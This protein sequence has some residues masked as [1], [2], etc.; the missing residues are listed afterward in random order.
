MKNFIRLC[1]S[2]P[3]TVIMILGAVF[4]GAGFSLSTL[5]LEK[6]PE[7]NYP[8]VTVETLYPGMGA[9]EMRSI[10]TIPVEDA[11]SSV[12]GLE[13]MRSVSRAGSSL[14]VLDF[15][16][17]LDAN[18]AS[19][20]VREAIDAVY[21]S[22]P[23][24][25]SKPT[26]VPGD[27][28][29]E[30]HAIIAVR[31]RS[32]D[33]VFA[34]NL[35]EYELRSRLRRIEG[36]GS[37]ILCGGEKP[38]LKLYLDIRKAAAQGFGVSGFSQLLAA[39]TAD[40]P[41]GSAREGQEELV[42]LSSGK[43]ESEAE[44]ASLSLPGV[45]G[46]LNLKSIAE[47][48]EAGA[49]L[50]SVFVF[51]GKIQCGLEI[52]RRPGADPVRLSRDIR[53]IVE[54]AAAD[55]SR[56][57]EIGMVMDSSKSIVRS[58]HDLGVSALLGAVAV[59]L[60]L[61]FF[62]R[63]IRYSLLTAFSIP[64]S[65]AASCIAL[66]LLDKSL[67]SMSLA[68]LTL[69]IGLVSDTA[70]IILDM[71]HRN[72]DGRCGRGG[73]KRD[74]GASSYNGK[75][76]MPGDFS[77]EIAACTAQ[78]SAS[79]FG[80]TLTT[81]VVF[82]PI[83]FLP[84]PLGALFADL[85]IALT[86]SIGAG[87]CYA[88]FVLPVLFR[89]FYKEPV[90]QVKENDKSVLIGLERAYRFFLRCSLR[91]PGRVCAGAVLLSI[92]GLVLLLERPAV[93]VSPEAAREV[94]LTIRFPSGM[95]LEA[96][97]GKAPEISDILS[98]VEGVE[99]VYGRAGAEAEDLGRRADPDF[100]RETFLF[101]CLLRDNAKPEKVLADIRSRVDEIWRKGELPAYTVLSADFPQDKTEALLG[102]SGSYSLAVH[103]VSREE[104]A[105][106]AEEAEVILRD[107]LGSSLADLRKRPSGTRTELRFFPDREALSFLGVSAMQI[108]ETVYASTEGIPSTR[109]DINGRPLE[110]KVSGKLESKYRNA[111]AMLET[112]P[113]VSGNGTPIFIK[114][115]GRIERRE[116]EAGLARL[117]RQD[118]S[119][120]D[121]VR[122]AG[123]GSSG[124]FSKE[125]EKVEAAF[126]WLSRADESVFSR[127][128]TSLLVVL[129]LVFFLLYMTMGAQFES[130]SL[131]LIF[132][133]T[134]PFSLAGVGPCMFIA[135][136][137]L[138]SG[139]ALGLI[140]LF[141]IAVNNGII[142]YEISDE[143][144]RGGASVVKA[145][146]SGSASRM[147]PVLITTATTVLVLLPLVLTPLGASQRAMAAAM[148]GGMMAGTLLSF[149]ALPPV[150]I[151]FFRK[152]RRFM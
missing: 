134:I 91:H 6:L 93:F 147:Q 19:A 21:P 38:E 41:A 125:I 58:M 76:Q 49:R 63:R 77:E 37:V 31:S 84:G 75:L 70:V 3:I 20:L 16:W 87:W 42:V 100:R 64:V 78:V 44:L 104:T 22:L 48:R 89:I 114:T 11:L 110:V 47:L 67:N 30:P 26:V 71:L 4:L 111:E 68:G 17:G 50:E 40:I 124:D 107:R 88:Q 144:I 27:P 52:Y 73:E 118:V 95:V 96:V 83:I 61:I 97:G 152:R 62:I 135:G 82:V 149:F 131:P 81:A 45:Q 129:V 35:A 113:L 69:G 55:F 34:R 90:G 115:L 122:A 24:G 14:I 101:R 9:S 56:D 123:A 43:P 120:L 92:L 103:S 18:A 133:L 109:L 138:D 112:I 140:A 108:A 85:S 130:F 99:A 46:P 139:A 65:A 74:K 66:A 36:A 29:I 94:E 141:G 127:Y 102:L 33:Q 86:V 15:R 137:N 143:Y 39:E 54:E 72:F 80:S 119:Y 60:T 105:S 128:R 116:T 145:V 79:S 28:K 23:E 25:V 8:R 117:D 2:R 148:L 146:Y 142:L 126:P 57:A 136:A 151:S 1:V 7:I 53:R 150:F 59:I 98:G 13:S 51:D 12:K 121:L 106:K 5:P 132:M 32:G 10:V